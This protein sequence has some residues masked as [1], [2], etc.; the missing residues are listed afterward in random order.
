MTAAN[1]TPSPA[2]TTTPTSAHDAAKPTRSEILSNVL[3]LAMQ[4]ST[5]VE[6]FN[7]IHP[8]NE[9]D[10]Q[11]KV[12]LAK[13]GIQQGRLLIWGDVMGISSPPATIARHMIPSQPGI[14]NPDPTVPVN[15]GVR[16]PRLDDPENNAKIHAA[17]D[18]IAGRPS[19]MSRE[20]LM[21]QYGLKS[22]KRLSATTYA[23]LDTNRLEAFREKF[24][25]L[26]DLVRQVGVRGHWQRAGSMTLQKWVVKNTERFD[27]FVK[28]VRLEVDG[29]IELMGVKEQVDRGMKTDIKAMAWH[30]ELTGPIVRA[31]WEK[32]KLIREAVVDDYPEYEETADR[33]LKYISD[34]LKEHHFPAGMKLQYTPAPPIRRKSS[35]DREAARTQVANGDTKPTANVNTQPVTKVMDREKG[36]GKEKEKDKKSS[37]FSKLWWGGGNTRKNRSKSIAQPRNEETDPQR[38]L[39]ADNGK[40]T[41]EYTADLSPV[42]SQSLSAIP[43]EHPPINLDSVLAHKAA[44]NASDEDKIHNKSNGA[45]LAAIPTNQTAPDEDGWANTLTQAETARSLIDRHDMYKDI[46]RIETKDI[47]NKSKEAAA[48]S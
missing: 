4:F 48:S 19:N 44:N 15:F 36:T 33:A 11:Q 38:S 17:L 2:T 9:G 10:R 28:T 16:D 34:E 45:E 46:G 42:R 18:E 40:A 22:P 5:C 31:D 12:A 26:K 39:S 23:A 35:I 13:L 29:L 6:A 37:I 14:T 21:L 30:P 3:T 41:F 47:R 8:H 24:A 25:L 32:L 43:D 7:L 20:A 1:Q 27:E